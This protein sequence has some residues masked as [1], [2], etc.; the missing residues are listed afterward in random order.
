MALMRALASCMPKSGRYSIF[1]LSLG[2]TLFVVLSGSSEPLRLEV[3]YH[4]LA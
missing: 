2:R 1:Y 3:L 4:V